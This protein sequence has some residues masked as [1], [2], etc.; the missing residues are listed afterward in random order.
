MSGIRVS[1]RGRA[2]LACDYV[3]NDRLQDVVGV[4]FSLHKLIIGDLTFIDNYR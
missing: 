3:V 4:R 1:P 2:R